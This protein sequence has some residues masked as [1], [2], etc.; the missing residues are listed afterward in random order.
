MA[1][2]ILSREQR[3]RKKAELQSLYTTLASYR[4]RE[5]SYIE[6]SAAIPEVLA[7]QIREIRQ[8]IVAIESELFAPSEATSE[9]RALAFYKEALEAD[10]A[11]DF[12]K[13]LRLYKSAGRYGHSDANAA[14]RSARYALKRAKSKPARTFMPAP[15][16][17]ARTRLLTGL[18]VLALI[19]LAAGFMLRGRFWGQPSS[20]V[21]GGPPTV[22]APS[23]TAVV[24]APDTPTPTPAAT[25]TDTPLPPTATPAFSTLPTP[26]LAPTSTPSSTTTP[27]PTLKPPPKIIE[28]K[29]DLVWGDGAIVFEFVDQKL[30][31]DELYCLNRMRG[32]DITNTENWSHEPRGSKKPSV[33]VEANVFR[34]ARAQGMRCIVWSA[35]IGQGSCDNIISE[36]TEERVIGLPRPCDFK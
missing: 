6:A 19:M 7:N 9:R 11:G 31:S 12:S 13:A 30:N 16:N 21:A 34:V 5:S 23:P 2:D 3:I 32:Y 18:G 10:L 14:A 26:T 33:A 28:P 27:A 24:I 36:S 35:A 17:P 8:N 1:N 22:A 15:A 29:N 20:V 4:D 25:P